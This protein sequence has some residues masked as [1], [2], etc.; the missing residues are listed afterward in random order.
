MAASRDDP[1]KRA[2]RLKARKAVLDALTSLG[3]EARRDMIL[4]RALA[5]GGF[6]TRELMAPPPVSAG[7]K[8]DRLIDCELSWALTNLKRDGLLEK[9]KWGHWR[10]TDAGLPSEESAVEEPV[11]AERLAKLRSMPYPFYLRTPEWRRTR[12]AAL[13]RAGNACS[14]D[15]TH[16]R[17][18][19][20]HHRTY[21]RRGEELVT[22]LIVLCHSCHQ[23]HHKAHGLPRKESGRKRRRFG[24]W[25]RGG[26]DSP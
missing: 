1:D 5:D 24:R 19:E 11:A 8:Y 17:D 13:V 26:P 3:G 12:A 20:V 22:D 6:T 10:L 7:E 25:W 14:L 21:E 16:T 23:L 15:V 4:E 2:L 18:L 9:P